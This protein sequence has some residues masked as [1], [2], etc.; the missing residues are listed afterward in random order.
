MQKKSFGQVTK[1]LWKL[2]TITNSEFKLKY[3][4]GIETY[5]IHD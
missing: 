1:I 3:F 4:L 5:L 2:D